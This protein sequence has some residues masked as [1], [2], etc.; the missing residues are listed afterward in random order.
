MSRLRSA[1]VL[2]AA[3]I[4]SLPVSAALLQ[5]SSTGP[6]LSMQ[7]V[8]YNCERFRGQVKW[9]DHQKGYGFIMR[10]D[11]QRDIFV[12][13]TSIQDDRGQTLS[14]GE[15]VEFCIGQGSNGPAA[16]QVVRI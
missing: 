10:D 2:C 5:S 11:G 7:A 8:Q 3:S 12:H 15:R 14:E 16:I 4:L 1:V 6:T 9:F 13:Y